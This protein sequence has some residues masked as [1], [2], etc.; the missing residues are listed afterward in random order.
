MT[1]AQAYIFIMIIGTLAITGIVLSVFIARGLATVTGKT[2][3]PSP[4][5]SPNTGVGN[6]F[7]T[8]WNVTSA[9]TDVIMFF[10]TAGEYDLTVDWGDGN[11]E[12]YAKAAGIAYTG[13]ELLQH[14]YTTTGVYDIKMTGANMTDWDSQGGTNAFSR[15]VFNGVV[16]G[17]SFAYNLTN[18]KMQSC[19]NIIV[20]DNLDWTKNVSNFS[21]L[22]KNSTF[23]LPIGA[24]DTSSATTMDSMFYGATAFNQPI[25]SWDTSNVDSMASMFFG[26]TAFNHPIGD[27]DTDNVTTMDSMFRSAAA[28]NQSIGS[29][30]TGNVTT[31]D[32][33]F[34]TATIFNQSIGSWNT[35]NV[36]I[37]NSMFR[38]AA[39]FNQP[40]N[41]WNTSNVNNMAGMFNGAT[42]FN[43]P[44]GNW[45]TS[46]V[47]TMA[48]MFNGATTF[49][50]PIGT[51]NTVNVATMAS[52]VLDAIA[53]NQ[54][55]N[56]LNFN[57][58]TGGGLLNIINSSGINTLN[59]SDLLVHW[60]VS[61]P[62]GG[63]NIGTVP[64]IYDASG[65]AARTILVG[66]G[67]TIPLNP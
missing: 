59:Y 18:L 2:P 43:Q 13:S 37:M 4:S 5:P 22:F 30:N 21:S 56:N 19:N 24:W 1:V 36:T 33:M 50:Q 62:T 48:G 3:S 63:F 12:T 32:S 7:I 28:F 25:G 67:W 34:D 60:S 45:N 65:D 29:W 15:G 14:Q 61:I 53:F 51:W 52:L 38:S 55:L 35:G 41:N 17:N 9:L 42:T 46:N 31:M 44:I 6:K 10:N 20:M 58:I 26:A 57:S 40:I 47:T 39:A 27:W 66:N 49:N 54:P 16:Q 11:S 23:N 64:V 8:R